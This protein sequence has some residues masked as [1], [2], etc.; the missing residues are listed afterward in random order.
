M[1]LNF[2]DI[3]EHPMKKILPLLLVFLLWLTACGREE[4]VVCIPLYGEGAPAYSIVR[5]DTSDGEELEAA[6]LLRNTLRDCGVDL[7][8]TTDWKTNPVSA[9]ELVVGDTLRTESEAGLIPDPLTL[10]R[11]GYFVKV[12]G[13]RVYM[14]GGSESAVIDAV[15]HFL[16]QF[17][18]WTGGTGGDTVLT[19]LQIPETYEYIYA[20]SFPVTDIT[21][22]G[23]SLRDC[24]LTWDTTFLAPHQPPEMARMVQDAFYT[25][26]GI[27]MDIVNPAEIT[28][29][30][31]TVSA[32]PAGSGQKNFEV[33][34]DENGLFMTTGVK[35]GFERGFNRFFREYF[36]DAA[37]VVSME[38]D[39]RYET[40]IGS[41]VSYSEFG[42]VGDGVTNDM[43]A[44]IR[45]HEFA[46]ASG[47]PVKADEGAVYY[48]ASDIT[49]G[50]VI[51]TDTD[52]TGASF[53]LDDRTVP[54]DKRTLNIFTV[55]AS[56][57]HYT[58]TDKLT[59]LTKLQENIG[60]TLPEDSLV[61]LTDSDT[62]RYIRKGVNA[63][64][65]SAQTDL[66]VVDTQGNVDMRSPLIWDYRQITEA[67]VI[68]MDT[69]HITIK[70]GTFTTIAPNVE[71]DRSYYTRGISVRRSN[72]TVQG[73]TQYVENE[74]P[75]GVSYSGI[76]TIQDCAN[77]LVEDCI[78]TPHR[79]HWFYLE[80]GTR[81]SQGTYDIGPTRA[82]NL[83]FRNCSQTYS[84]TDSAYWGI[85]GSNFCKNI[86]VEGCSFSRFDAHQGVANVTL[87]RSEFGVHGV[88][89][90]GLGTARIEDCLLY[91][92][93]MVNFRS[94][95][96]SHWEGELILRNCTWMP[97]Q[98]GELKGRY[99]AINGR[100][101][102]DHDFGY[103]C[104]MPSHITIEN[105]RV[106][107]SKATS[108]YE[109]IVLFAPMNPARTDAAAEKR[110]TGA[111]G[112]SPYQVTEKLTIS[113]YVSDSGKDWV[114]TAN[115][116]LFRGML[117]E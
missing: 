111:A 46:N 62:K 80:D 21:V 36:A 32:T 81:F 103:P 51:Q 79:T 96:G 61:I 105:L 85:M 3:K 109:G 107:D 43:E 13:T 10:G 11:E 37:G 73:I 101:D 68:P 52:W 95:Y 8:I 25:T 56:K 112:Y 33:T 84:I 39:F 97:G 19:S 26:C 71:P 90:I 99:Y 18:G 76:L 27:W 17:C 23:I 66:I 69:E 94:D 98:G 14:N 75:D 34:A 86:V 82:V 60:V 70:G 48:I 42:A 104:S 114:L 87:L 74:G 92:N 15:E 7:P 54:K 50:A 117:V 31:V 106:A 63:N 28:G 116:W 16:T 4:P 113:G 5:S 12:V 102:E 57:P 91:G 53:L 35:M 44:I 58:I 77:V 93:S 20:Q 38:A 41:S 110:I 59:T 78:F 72:V 83:T 115:P 88:N 64:S 89:L 30:A 65:G 2:H 1:N 6:L 29:P 67:R 47:V 108:A 24:V 45:T 9:Y 55:T 49:A 40:D 22:N 100:N